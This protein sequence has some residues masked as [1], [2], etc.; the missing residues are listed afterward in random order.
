MTLETNH[1]HERIEHIRVRGHA[2]VAD[3]RLEGCT[4]AVCHAGARN[5]LQRPIFRRI[6][7]K[8][9]RL[10]S[11]DAHGVVFDDCTVDGLRTNRL[12]MLTGCAF[13]RVTLRGDLGQFVIRA[14]MAS[15]PDPLDGANREFYAMVDWALDI[16]D[17][18]AATLDIRDVP[19]HLVRRN[20]ETQAIIHKAH[21][22]YEEML[23]RGLGPTATQLL[24][25]FFPSDPDRKLFV[26]GAR[27]KTFQRWVEAFAQLRKAGLAE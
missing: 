23:R 20:P 12:S 26:A 5:H 18:R 11:C 16:R 7:V 8:N 17:V 13:R 6:V 1:T 24:S 9:C 25:T 2:V 4:F 14:S 22:P 21:L 27:S 19:L 3:H 15:E 10:E